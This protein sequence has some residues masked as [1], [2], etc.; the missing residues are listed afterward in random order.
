MYSYFLEHQYSYS[1][2]W[3]CALLIEH[4][5]AALFCILFRFSNQSMLVVG[6]ALQHRQFYCL[7]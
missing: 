7:T 1:V 3:L 4:L 2:I 5:N 6:L